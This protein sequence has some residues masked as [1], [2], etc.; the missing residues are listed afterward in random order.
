MVEVEV[1]VSDEPVSAEE[2]N[3]AV[4]VN[5]HVE[6][7]APAGSAISTFWRSFAVA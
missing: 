1:K 6:P 3:S 2:D 4:N 5:S 7:E